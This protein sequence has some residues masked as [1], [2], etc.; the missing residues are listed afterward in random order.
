MGR[1]HLHGVVLEGV[2][3][4]G[5]EAGGAV[6]GRRVG[7]AEVVRGLSTEAGQAGVVV[8]TELGDPAVTSLLQCVVSPGA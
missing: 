6:G 1:P 8:E 4:G 3:D 7:E 5:G 2:H